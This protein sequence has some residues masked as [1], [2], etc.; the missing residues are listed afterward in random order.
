MTNN[1]GKNKLPTCR[2]KYQHISLQVLSLHLY[3]Y[4]LVKIREVHSLIHREAPVDSNT[5]HKIHRHKIYLKGRCV[6]FG[7]EIQTQE[8]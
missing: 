2:E 6:A 3:L 8:L 4:M 1:V 7:E 5:G